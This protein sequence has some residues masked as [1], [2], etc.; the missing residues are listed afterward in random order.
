MAPNSAEPNTHLAALL[1]Q[2]L[3]QREACEGLKT[4]NECA[5]ALHAAQNL[6]IPFAD[7]KS[8]SPAER[9]SRL[10]SAPSSPTLMLAQRHAGRNN[11]HAAT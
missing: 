6:N 5:T 11:R 9:S 1:P 2:G 10:Q 7:L 8:H 3:S 4:T